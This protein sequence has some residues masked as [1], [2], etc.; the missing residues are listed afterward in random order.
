MKSQSIFLFFILVTVSLYGNSWQQS[1]GIDDTTWNAISPYL[2]PQDHPVKEKLDRIFSK[3][4]VLANGKTFKKAGFS[5][6]ALRQW[7]NAVVAWHSK[8]KGYVIKAYFDDQVGVDYAGCLIRRVTG[9][10]AI[11]EAID[12]YHYEHLFKV[13]QKWIYPIQ[14]FQPTEIKPHKKFFILVAEDMKLKG[15]SANAKK[16]KKIKKDHLKALFHLVQSLGLFDSI[17]IT[18]IPF[19][20]DNKI[21]FIDTEHHHGWPIRLHRLAPSLSSKMQEYWQQL[22]DSNGAAD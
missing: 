3:P 8:L 11:Q 21:A 9:A 18:N 6:L 2:L 7:D 15:R 22:I 19:A 12:A 10:R 20:K 16:W 17:Y 4:E 5:Y 13:P 14:F 1:C